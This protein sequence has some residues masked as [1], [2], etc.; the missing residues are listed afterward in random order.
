MP[1]A[2]EGGYEV[3]QL[4]I[5]KGINTR[6]SRFVTQVAEV[7]IYVVVDFALVAGQLRA[8][9]EHGRALLAL[10]HPPYNM[11]EQLL[12]LRAILEIQSMFLHWY[13]ASTSSRTVLRTYH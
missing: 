12:G 11:F 4:I 2:P 1:L 9:A 7:S 10:E 3:W 13:T 5:I 8:A 6:Y